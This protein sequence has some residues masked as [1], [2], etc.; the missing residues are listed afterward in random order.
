MD[1][2]VMSKLPTGT[3]E[4]LVR[5]AANSTTGSEFVNWAIHALTDG[6]DSPSLRRLAGLA[7]N[8]TTFETT[9]LF[10]RALQE[11]ELPIPQSK[12]E[13]YRKFLLSIAH[14]IVN[15]LRSVESALQVIHRQVLDPLNHPPDLM[16]W[17]Y[18]WEGLDPLTFDSLDEDAIATAVRALAR[19]TVA[20]DTVSESSSPRGT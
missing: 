12:E 2:L 6:H 18:L 1:G 15:G 8:T 10:D 9:P 16:P 7:E 19:D 13:L 14:D 20:R 3:I 4:L 11:L 5:H 17:C